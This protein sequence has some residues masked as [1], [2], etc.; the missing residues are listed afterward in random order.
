MGKE[1]SGNGGGGLLSIFY[2]T[3]GGLHGFRMY[4]Y[5]RSRVTRPG[6]RD[7]GRSN[8]RLVMWGLP[9]ATIAVVVANVV[10]INFYG[11][12]AVIP[13][14]LLDV[15]A[16]VGL[17]WLALVLWEVAEERRR[18]VAYVIADVSYAGAPGQVKSTMRRIHKHARA[19]RGGRAHQEGMFGDV[20]LD[21]LVYEAAEQ[22]V[23]SSELSGAIADLKESASSDD[24]EALAAASG[25]VEDIGR[26]L[27]RVEASLKRAATTANRLSEKIVR[28]EEERAAR[29]L[30]EEAAAAEADRRAQAMSRLNTATA[31]ASVQPTV[32]VADVE[33]RVTAVHA[34]YEEVTQV[35]DAVLQGRPTPVASDQAPAKDEPEEDRRRLAREAVWKVTKVSAS[36]AGKFSAAAAK[37]GGDKFRDRKRAD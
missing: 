27:Q 8:M 37:A 29:Q 7:P 22:A 17:L 25:Q 21:Q 2:L 33:D 9:V 35:S 31:R 32:D 26:Y 11:G 6:A 36:K 4:R 23:I 12:A 30:A 15:V 19:M 18:R 13:A 1:T 10:A 14:L 24:R 20:G 5:V 34:G 16:I 3:I 28:P